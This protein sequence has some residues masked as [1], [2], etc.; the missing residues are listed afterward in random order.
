MQ[1]PIYSRKFSLLN[2]THHKTRDLEVHK[3]KVSESTTNKSQLKNN[4]KLSY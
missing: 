4:N 3:A 2:K 1:K